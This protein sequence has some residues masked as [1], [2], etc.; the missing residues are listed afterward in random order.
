MPVSQN[1]PDPNILSFPLPAQEHFLTA[2][3]AAALV[4]LSTRTLDHHRIKGTG[5]QYSRLGRRIVYTRANIN[6]WVA[7]REFG[8]TSEEDAARG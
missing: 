8:S 6:A 3:Q 7:G 5:P 2:K 1:S 4:G